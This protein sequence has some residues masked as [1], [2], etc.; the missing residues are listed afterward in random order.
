MG[1]FYD[2]DKIKAM[3]AAAASPPE[4]TPAQPPGTKPPGGHFYDEE[5]IKAMQGGSSP[6]SGGAQ[7]L[8]KIGLIALLV[9][10]GV[11]MIAWKLTHNPATMIVNVNKA[12]VTELSYLPGIGD[13]KAKIIIDH[14]P[15]ATIEDLKKL[16]GIGE[17]TFEKMKPRVKVE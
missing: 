15:Y 8:V 16:P 14:R 12:S 11:I 5:K 2:E 9:I 13:A 1:Q 4:S 7:N 10:V 3:E 17:K 6:A